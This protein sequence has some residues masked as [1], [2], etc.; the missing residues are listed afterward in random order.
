MERW[1]F[2][3]GVV[4]VSAPSWLTFEVHRPYF[5]GADSPLAAVQAR[6]PLLAARRFEQR[7]ATGLRF[8][9]NMPLSYRRLLT[10]E[11][12][13][14]AYRVEA[15]TDLPAGLAS[16][17]WARLADAYR[18]REQLD[19]TDRATLAYW[20]V[21]V[22]LP[23]AV[24]DVVPRDLE[25]ALC[26]DPVRAAAQAARATA[27]FQAEG[28][29]AR[30]TAAYRALVEDPAPTLCHA[31]AVASWGYLLARHAG[32]DSA[33][34]ELARR[35]RELLERAADG[36]TAFEYG[37]ARVRL[38][39]REVMRAEREHAFG[40]AARQ[41]RAA[42]E[43][44]AGLKPEDPEDELLLLESRRRLVDRSLEIAVRLDDR[45]AEQQALAEGVALDPYCVKIR[46]Q[47]AQAQQ[48]LGRHEQALAGY[49]HA[50]RLGPH[51]TGF[52]LVNAAECARLAGHAEFA[53]ELSE[54]A[55]RSAPRSARTA[56]LLS[57]SCERSGTARSRRSSAGPRAATRSSRTTTTGTSRCT[58][59]ISTW[60]SRSPPT[61]MPDCPATPTSS[62]RPE[63]P[64][65]SPGS[66]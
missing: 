62:P 29:S 36:L 28:L 30:T 26:R 57:A 41:L 25:P 34:P 54:R 35:A 12:R 40:R 4:G 8:G 16:P 63:P 37:T 7:S 22:C 15:P 60:A 49:L 53:R 44:V 66:G 59:P 5:D 64:R 52:A 13:L 32:D 50:A 17:S 2:S 48:R 43:A 1:R 20:L 11:S 9:M 10:E 65:R 58:P 46:M 33:A 18:R 42:T 39:L 47:Q 21:A 55:F 56:E 51:G 6:A 38:D 23:G 31:Q 19:P 14:R 61:S 24:L 45:E 27:L 3:H